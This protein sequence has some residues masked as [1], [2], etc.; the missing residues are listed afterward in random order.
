M[1]L[2]ERLELLD[3]LRQVPETLQDEDWDTLGLALHHGH[4]MP[5]WWEAG[6]HDN[7]LVKV[8]NERLLCIRSHLIGLYSDMM[9]SIKKFVVISEVGF[10][11]IKARVV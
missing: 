11:M 9:V 8:A 4:D 7:S 2:K 1:R 5:S 3:T 6:Y 10:I